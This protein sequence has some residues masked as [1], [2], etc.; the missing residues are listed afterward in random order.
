MYI[1]LYVFE[2]RVI[3][4][5]LYLILLDGFLRLDKEFFK[6]IKL[7]LLVYVSDLRMVIFIFYV[8]GN[9]IIEIFL[10]SLFRFCFFFKI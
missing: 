9:I 1:F 7:G 5:V 2:G 8:L 3:F 6:I 4:K 10:N